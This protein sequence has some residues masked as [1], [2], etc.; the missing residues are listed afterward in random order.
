MNA[1]TE[2]FAGEDLVLLGFPSNLFNMQE[3]AITPDEFF[4]GVRWVRPGGNF[5]NTVTQFFTKID[6]NG[7]YEDPF[8]TYLKGTCDM[9]FT[10]YRTGLY[11]SPLRVGDVYWN[12][13]KFLIGRDGIPYTRYNPTMTSADALI[14]DIEYL[15]SQ[16]A[17]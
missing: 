16:P 6:V 8:Y 11:Y 7:A 13:E 14:P 12:Y 5:N 17:H 1:I 2:Y 10:E 4:N 15:L 9:T 3:P